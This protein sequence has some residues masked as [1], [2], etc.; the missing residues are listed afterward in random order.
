MDRAP[1]IQPSLFSGIA[2]QIIKPSAT[3]EGTISIAN[4]WDTRRMQ[5][6][7]EIEMSFYTGGKVREVVLGYTSHNGV[8]PSQAIDP[9]ME[10]Y[11]NSVMHIRDTVIPGPLNTTIQST[12]FDK[13]HILSD[14]G[15]N[16]ILTEHKELR[17]RP[18][19]VYSTM[20]SV[21]ASSMMPN[22]WYD[23]RS[24]STSL[25]AKSERSNN[26]AATYM[27][28]IL[29]GYSTAVNDTT[30]I[31]KSQEALY[32]MTRGIVA[33]PLATKDAFLSAIAQIRG[34]GVG[35]TFTFKNL[36]DLDP[37]VEH[38]TH[39]RLLGPSAVNNAH[40]VGQTAD[41]GGSDLA[42]S[43]A[44]ILSNSVPSLMMDLAL[45]KLIFK[46]TNRTMDGSTF[47]QFGDVESFAN[48]ELSRQLEVF[49][50]RVTL[51]ILND[52]SFNNQMDFEIAMNVDL[53]GETWISIS[54]NAEPA[55]DY[56]TPSFCDALLVPVVTCNQ[57]LVT[58]IAKD[59]EVM[60][61]AIIGDRD[62]DSRL[63]FA[64]LGN[65]PTSSGI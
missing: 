13:S 10:F 15:W 28:N 43:A 32:S 34:T 17:L 26:S 51:E 63:D 59:F 16:G 38:V 40:N 37:G 24:V 56:V 41:W 22:S 23:G 29:D 11:V 5:F 12:I 48:T 44:T 52:I 14:P 42:T 53:V 1:S 19:D 61:H 27:A 7:M 55:T 31:G 50:S 60:A 46:A 18:E 54:F 58:N 3:P 57:Q 39:A 4:G 25:A 6:M 30:N 35:M 62:M 49:K 9:N 36:L 33:S 65:G 8:S 20:S 21:D 2:N 45:T 64:G 47:I